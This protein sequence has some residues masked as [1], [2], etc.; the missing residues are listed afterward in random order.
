MNDIFQEAEFDHSEAKKL[1]YFKKALPFIIIGTIAIITAMV[2]SN[3]IT[4]KRTKHNQ[5]MGDIF[6]KAV[7]SDD[8][9]L[10]RESIDLLIKDRA[11]GMSDIARLVDIRVNVKDADVALKKLQEVASEAK[12]PITK[13][14]AMLLWMNILVDKPEINDAER[15]N[16]LKYMNNFVDETTPFFGTASIAKALYQVKTGDVN[17]AKETLKGILSSSNV[18]PVVKDEAN[19]ILS[20]LD[21]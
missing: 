17:L 6:I 16:M 7:Q 12:N 19:S 1:K 14:Y 4:T 2:L 3:W 8:P 21:K 15:A 20:G 18:T 5:E 9:K 11:N 10:S 13:Y